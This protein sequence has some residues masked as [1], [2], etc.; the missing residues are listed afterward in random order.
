[1]KSALEDIGE[2]F[3]HQGILLATPQFFRRGDLPRDH[4][5]LISV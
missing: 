3:V 2:S 4:V 5:S 1:M